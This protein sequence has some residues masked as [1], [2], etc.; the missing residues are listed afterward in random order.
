MN[1][2]YIHIQTYYTI[3][4]SNIFIPS[5]LTEYKYQIYLFLDTWPNTNIEYIQCKPLMTPPS[6]IK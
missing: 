1:I 2:E 3:R 5:N 4:M 6:L